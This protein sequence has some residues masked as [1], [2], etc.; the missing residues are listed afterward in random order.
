MKHLI[1]AILMS[2]VMAFFIAGYA[3]AQWHGDQ[4]SQR[5]SCQDRFDAFDTN[6]DGKLT[7]DNSW[8]RRITGVTPKKCSERW[9][10]TDAVI[11]QKRSSV[12]GRGWAD[13]L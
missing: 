11:L 6:H 7:K 2:L 4:G 1:L 13:E 5:M 8:R 10:L 12:R 3:F 9:M